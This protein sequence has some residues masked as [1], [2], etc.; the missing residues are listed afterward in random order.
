MTLKNKQIR[1]DNRKVFGLVTLL[2]ALIIF[3]PIFIGFEINAANALL[4]LVSFIAGITFTFFM[5][6]TI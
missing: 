6:N 4:M 2:H 1:K 5:A 3:A